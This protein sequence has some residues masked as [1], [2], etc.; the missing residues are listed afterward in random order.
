MRKGIEKKLQKR[1]VNL[2][3]PSFIVCEAYF[4]KNTTLWVLQ[5]ESSYFLWDFNRRVFFKK[6]KLFQELRPSSYELY[7]L[8]TCTLIDFWIWWAMNLERSCKITSHL[9][10]ILIGVMTIVWA[11]FALDVHIFGKIL[12]LHANLGTF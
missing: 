5:V 10:P 12:N 8:E 3:S 6:Q 11:K 1:E 9:L 7:L 4:H 2:T